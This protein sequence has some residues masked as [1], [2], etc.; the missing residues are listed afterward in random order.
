MKYT[1]SDLIA[2]GRDR[3]VGH[4][5]IEG[6]VG[7][8]NIRKILASTP[9]TLPTQYQN[10]S[11]TSGPLPNPS[12][13]PLQSIGSAIEMVDTVGELKDS[14]EGGQSGKKIAK[15]I[16][17]DVIDKSLERVEEGRPNAK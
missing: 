10:S 9:N 11:G 4:R 1:Q 7:P 3:I 15:S 8:I 2:Q 5:R 6:K 12:P 16:T 17:D 13:N 14:L